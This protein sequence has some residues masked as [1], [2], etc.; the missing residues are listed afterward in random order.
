MRIELASYVMETLT[1]FIRPN[2]QL[3]NPLPSNPKKDFS[4]AKKAHFERMGAWME[5][6]KEN[7]T[8]HIEQAHSNS[9]YRMSAA[10]VCP[11]FF[12]GKT[13]TFTN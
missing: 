8:R 11:D 7:P 4:I 5:I 3:L 2:P 13:S 1:L 12:I 9:S 6:T 10:R